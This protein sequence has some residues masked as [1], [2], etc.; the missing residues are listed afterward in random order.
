MTLC[1]N[2]REKTIMSSTHFNG[3]PGCPRCN[4][5][6]GWMIALLFC[7]LPELAAQTASAVESGGPK[8]MAQLVERAFEKGM[9]SVIVGLQTPAVAETT[10]EGSLPEYSEIRAIEHAQF[11]LI[12]QM[13]GYDISL[14]KR[15]RYIPFMALR[16]DIAGL[17]Q[18]ASLPEV[19]S[20]E[21]DGWLRPELMESVPLIGAP[22]AWSYGYSGAG[23]TVA[24]LDTGI[25]K[26]HPLLA[27]KVVAEGC[28]STNIPEAGISSLC[29]SGYPYSTVP[30]S[31][32]DCG[33]FSEE[34]QHG[35]HVAGIAAGKGK[36]ISGVAPE[37][38]LIAVQVFSRSDNPE[39]CGTATPCTGASFSDVIYGLEYVYSLQQSYSIAAVNMSL[40]GA[41]YSDKS[42]DDKNPSLAAIMSRLKTAGIATVVASGNEQQTTSIATPAC[43]SSAVSVG[44]TGDGS[45]GSV[46]DQVSFFS[47]SAT[48]LSLLA[49]GDR[50]NSSVP[51][52]SYRSWRGTSMAAPHVAGAFAVLKSKSPLAGV[53]ELVSVLKSTGLPV[54][55]WR[56]GL[57]TPRIRLDKAV[58]VLAPPNHVTLTASPSSCTIPA[59]TEYC[60]VRLTAT[61]PQSASLQVWMQRPGGSAQQMVLGTFIDK[62]FSF[63]WSWVELGHSTFYV[64]DVSQNPYR[65]LAHL[66][67]DTAL[68]PPSIQS[69]PAF[70]QVDPGQ[71]VCNVNINIYNAPQQWV[72]LWVRD[73][74]GIEK[75]VTGPLAST[76]YTVAIPWIQARTYVFTLYD[77]STGAFL[78]I[79]RILV[80]GITR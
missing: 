24:V 43:I 25:D 44:S 18:L 59:G 17:M 40:G 67:V 15:Y 21:E 66:E 68:A 56:N 34:C 1:R 11:R 5:R 8:T 79:D 62:V 10:V 71:G 39:E 53:D 76:T 32:L 42:C 16:V 28:F 13:L 7:V 65:L 38:N 20:I 55:D 54:Q 63:T 52:G 2:F 23:Q 51:G 61:N 22:T 31:G 60:A 37:A 29:P 78:P 35:T 80:T 75:P 48:N 50:I 72:Q 77:I 47:N 3:Y 45:G 70:C 36:T 41:P 74:A 9:I 6:F 73:G 33:V 26:Y 58:D 19:I 30:N 4:H 49:P 27:G 14:V 57:V 12:D 69:V 46:A 64:Y